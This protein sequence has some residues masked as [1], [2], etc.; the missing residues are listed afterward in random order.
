MSRR[1]GSRSCGGRCSGRRGCGSRGGWSRGRGSGGR[2]RSCWLGGW[3]ARVAETVDSIAPVIAV[4][5]KDIS[6]VCGIPG[7]SLALPVGPLAVRAGL[8]HDALVMDPALASLS[9]LRHSVVS[10]V[11]VLVVSVVSAAALGPLHAEL[12]GALVESGKSALFHGLVAEPLAEGTAVV[13]SIASQ[14]DEPD[15]RPARGGK[16][17]AQRWSG[18]VLWEM[19]LWEP[20]L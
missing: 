12:A 3:E 4:V 17:L 8:S 2:S 14:E 16:G 20:G 19:G 11:S 15:G 5:L 1:C 10:V 18:L 6:H 13:I 9:V 7:L